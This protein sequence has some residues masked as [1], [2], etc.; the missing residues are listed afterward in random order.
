MEVL[1]RKCMNKIIYIFLFFLFAL[2]IRATE[3]LS[4][5]Q[6]N[7]KDILLDISEKIE[8]LEKIFLLP[9]NLF[10]EN[11]DAS[12]A[13]VELDKLRVKLKNLEGEIEK[14]E[15]NLT[16]QLGH[17]RKNLEI[18]SI[19]L[20]EYDN[21][22]ELENGKIISSTNKRN[23]TY[24]KF[25]LTQLDDYHSLK[26]AKVYIENSEFD[27]AKAIF[28]DFLKNF[29]NSSLLPEVFFYLA[30][31]Y[32]NT[33][34]WKLAANSYLESFSLDPKGDFA[35]QALFGLAISLGA[36]EEFD[37]ACL[38]LEEVNLRFP[39]QKMVSAE[40]ILESKKLLSCY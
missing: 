38:T 15:Y 8:S 19:H 37:Q 25:D 28:K 22:F 36:L 20:K 26:R 17:I 30:E 7:I 11:G 3:S 34:D 9:K 6:K 35:P 12:I 10:I 2:E 32:Y 24:E 14:I 23:N 21:S 33:T 5:E 29:P 13:L 31:T 18:I 27:N 1:L 40:N 4:Y 16:S 39:G